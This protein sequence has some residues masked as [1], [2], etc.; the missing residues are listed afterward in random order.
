MVWPAR[1]KQ[2]LAPALAALAAVAAVAVGGPLGFVLVA[3]ALAAGAVPLRRSTQEHRPAGAELRDAQAARRTA[4]IVAEAAT[5]LL[6]TRHEPA[7][8]DP[9][10][11]N[12]L[13]EVGA[14]LQ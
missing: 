3:I 11:D 10:V 14:R 6:T 13:A 4:T 12:A 8:A 9:R 5:A 7:I 2:I 1:L